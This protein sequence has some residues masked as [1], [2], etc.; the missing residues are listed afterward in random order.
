MDDH[1]LPGLQHFRDELRAT[2]RAGMTTTITAAL[3]PGCAWD[4]AAGRTPF[5]TLSGPAAA[6]ASTAVGTS[7]TAAITAAA[8]A[9]LRPLETRAR[10]AADARGIPLELFAW[11]WSAG[12][13]GSASFAGEKDGVVFDD[14]FIDGAF[15]GY[16][17]N[18]LSVGVGMFFRSALG[19][20][21]RGVVRAIVSGVGLGFGIFG[22]RAF[23]GLLLGEFR[24]YGSRNFFV[25]FFVFFFVKL[26]ATDQR[27]GIGVGLRLFVLGFH[28]T[29][30]KSG[31][32]FL[33]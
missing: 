10:V 32:I 13:A 4:R 7:A 15:G 28:D 12:D 3:L 14:R 19:T 18:H 8:A 26:R 16:G 24:L 27:I 29:R 17:F 6:I 5:E 33:A 21:G 1:V 25:F 20:D 30:G 9:A 31:E 23:F 2:R 22:G 11:N